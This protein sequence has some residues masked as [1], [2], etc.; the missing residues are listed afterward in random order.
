MAPA[1]E[2]RDPRETG[3]ELRSTSLDK[4]QG[5]GC[6]DATGGAEA[7]GGGERE[8]LPGVGGEAMPEPKREK[9][10]WPSQRKEKGRQTDS[11]EQ[12]SHGSNPE[13]F[14]DWGMERSGSSRRGSWQGGPGWG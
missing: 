2:L 12:T 6:M 8:G 10:A 4:C 1:L 13:K 5:D 14:G 11:P 3:R 9:T 7:A